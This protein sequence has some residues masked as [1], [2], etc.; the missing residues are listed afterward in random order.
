M[1]IRAVSAVT[2]MILVVS[3]PAPVRAQE[4]A[5]PSSKLFADLMA[6]AEKPRPTS[7]AEDFGKAAAACAA[8]LGPASMDA[9]KIEA[10]GW[11]P[12]VKATSAKSAWVFEQKPS[13]VR[14]FLATIFSPAGQCVVDGFAMKK[15]DFGAIGDAVKSQVSTALGKKLKNMGANASPNGVSRG[16]GFRA[17]QLMVSI[18]MQVQANGMSTRITLMQIDNSKSAFETANAAGMAAQ[19]LPMM[20]GAKEAP[21]K[22][23]PPSKS[24][25][26]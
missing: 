10:V 1:Q 2:L 18:S 8:A 22:A 14:I 26:Q 17:D 5:R 24:L 12:T 13:H 11:T 16:Q 19:F 9:S 20:A 23:D 4:Q 21:E 6:D 15:G 25:P 3:T 7:P